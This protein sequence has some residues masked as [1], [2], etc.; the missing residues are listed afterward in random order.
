MI[1]MKPE[2]VIEEVKKSNMR[3]RGG[4]GFPTGLKWEFA[5]NAKGNKKYISAMLTKVN[6]AHSRTG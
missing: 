2:E 1:K 5:R 4:A 3:G 6:P